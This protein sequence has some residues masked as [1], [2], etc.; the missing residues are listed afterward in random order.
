[1]THCIR[2]HDT[3][4]RGGNKATSIQFELIT[5]PTICQ[6]VAKIVKFSSCCTM[7]HDIALIIH[8]QSNLSV[9]V[10]AQIMYCE[11]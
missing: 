2:T 11:P 9:L 5:A 10:N 7:L 6:P 4:Q 3:L 8:L 1:M